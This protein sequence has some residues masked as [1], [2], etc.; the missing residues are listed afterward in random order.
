MKVC[1]IRAQGPYLYSGGYEVSSSVGQ[2]EEDVTIT[3]RADY[4]CSARLARVRNNQNISR[5]KLY[6][7]TL[8]HKT[9]EMS[10]VEL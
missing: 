9:S 10:C 1:K 5:C 4:E 2:D 6:H 8:Q 3:E 7:E